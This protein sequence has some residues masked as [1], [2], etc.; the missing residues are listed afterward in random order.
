MDARGSNAVHSQSSRFLPH[1][2]LLLG[3]HSNLKIVNQHFN[4]EEEIEMNLLKPGLALLLTVL[5]MSSIPA[6]A[7]SIL[8]AGHSGGGSGDEASP[9][10][11]SLV[12]PSTGAVSVIGIANTGGGG[13]SGLASDHRT[14][15]ATFGGGVANLVTI[16]PSTGTVNQTIGAV[17][18]GGNACTIGDLAMGSS[19]VLYAITANGIGHVC[20]G[21]FANDV[22]AGTI[23]TID[24]ATGAATVLGR[25]MEDQYPDYIWFENV[26][27]GLAVDGAG[28][29]WLLPGWAHPDP[30]KIF[31]LNKSTGLVE[32]E[33]TLT[34]DL[35]NE[36]NGLAWNPDDGMLYASWEQSENQNLW[37]IDPAT[38]VTTLIADTGHNLHDLVFVPP[39]VACVGF[40][41]PMAHHP[42]K[43][44]KN[45]VFPLKMGLF[46]ADGFELTD[47][48]VAV[49]LVQ[50]MFDAVGAAPAV[51]VT[52]DALSSGAGTDGNQF[53]YTV[54]GIWQFNLKSK[55]YTGKGVYMVTAISGDPSEYTIDPACV[56]SFEIQ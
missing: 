54:D 5:A 22:E 17:T 47:A 32:S 50:V 38:G 41:A 31:I 15:Y 52:D 12:D 6:F 56:T 53:E 4:T 3:S 44:K 55:N 39:S 24:K 36:A 8:Y 49:P 33:L 43:A 1:A 9:G 7:Q 37:K 2:H 14:I 25:P 16:D 26:N 19:G 48:D 20:D 30:G 34:G 10:A 11:F 21:A 18:V 28:N 51:D 46:D 40:Q 27:G 13:V 45:R 35:L 42:V 29:L 23:L